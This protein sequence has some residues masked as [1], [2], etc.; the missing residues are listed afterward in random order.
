MRFP[1]LLLLWCAG[2][3]AQTAGF[4]G[5]AVN[6][7]TGQPL[8]GVHLKLFTLNV[9]GGITDAYGAMSGG[10]GRFSVSGIPPGTYVLLTERTGFVHMMAVAGT[11]PVPSVTLKAGERVTDYRLEMTPR[12]VI[13]VRVLDEY[14]DPAPNVMVEATPVAPGGPTAA[15]LNNPSSEPPIWRW[16]PRIPAPV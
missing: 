13:T 16:R 4:G 15:S 9:G 5:I 7:V 2:L 11:I 3:G 1:A 8:G 12:A 14:G 6:S 10:D